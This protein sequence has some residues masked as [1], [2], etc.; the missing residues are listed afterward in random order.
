MIVVVM[1]KCVSTMYESY[2]RGDT[3]ILEASLAKDFISRGWAT[4]VYEATALDPAKRQAVKQRVN[5]R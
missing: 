3:Y 2:S 1:N 5:K 4:P